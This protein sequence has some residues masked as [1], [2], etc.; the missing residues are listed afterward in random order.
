MKVVSEF[1]LAGPVPRSRVTSSRIVYSMY[2][3]P[4][5][6]RTAPPGRSN[7]GPSNFSVKSLIV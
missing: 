4:A 2:S 1:A 3:A 5:A 6:A 7:N